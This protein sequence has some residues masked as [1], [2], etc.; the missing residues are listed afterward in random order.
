MTTQT[1][2]LPQLGGILRRE[3]EEHVLPFWWR[4]ALDGEHDGLLNC[5]DETG[6]RLGT[7][8]FMWSQLRG[9]WVFSTLAARGGVGAA[10]NRK[11]AD[12]LFRFCHVHGRTPAGEWVFCV[13]RTGEIRPHPASIFTDGFAMLGLAAYLGLTGA[14]EG[15]VLLR[16]T[17]ASVQA[18]L[19]VPG[20]YG[21]HPYVLPAGAKNLGVAMLFSLAFWEAGEVLGDA[22]MKRQALG[23]ADEILGVF[24]SPEDD[25]VREFVR[26]DGG[27]LDGWQGRCCVP[28]HVIEGLWAV[29]RLYRAAGRTEGIARCVTLIRRHLELGWDR[30]FGGVTLA[31]DLDGGASQ[32]SYA[33]YKPWWTSV[34]TMY[35]LLL[36]YRESREPW[37]LEWYARV[38]NWA[39]THYPVR[40]DGEW[41]NRLNREGRPTADIIGLP[42]KDP[43][44]LPRALLF[45]AEVVAEMGN[46]PATLELVR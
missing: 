6:R 23:F 39:F 30:E 12:S 3:L 25:A 37:C 9:L 32:W 5:M 28:G 20:S 4:H 18:R 24:Y 31:I 33:T 38:H 19:A 40:P 43:F 13:S 15:R 41:R 21:I 11:F 35:G 2:T 44:H 1:T 10:E 7:D 45:S 29:M 27:P 42:V 46:D 17:V 14:E 34:E 8:K 16:Q 22:A 26:Q 36:A